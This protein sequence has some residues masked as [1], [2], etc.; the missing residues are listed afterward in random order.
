MYNHVWS[1]KEKKMEST[2]QPILFDVLACPVQEQ[3][4]WRLSLIYNPLPHDIVLME[5]MKHGMR[6]IKVSF[7]SSF[8]L[9]LAIKYISFIQ[10]WDEFLLMVICNIY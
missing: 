3:S 5:R 9:Q 7:F 4:A 1:W 10:L 2:G 8:K 6:A